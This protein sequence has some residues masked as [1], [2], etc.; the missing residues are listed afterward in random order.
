MEKLSDLITVF[1]KYES[2]RHPP[3]SFK[4]EEKGNNVAIQKGNIL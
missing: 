4:R 3:P 2:H 1:N